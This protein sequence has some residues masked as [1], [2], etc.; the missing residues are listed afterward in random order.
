MLKNHSKTFLHESKRPLQK[1]NLHDDF[2]E[3]EEFTRWTFIN[4]LIGYY[5]CD[6]HWPTLKK[7]RLS[8]DQN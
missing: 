8:F 6:S 1:T 5:F 4:L 3:T 2:L 7:S